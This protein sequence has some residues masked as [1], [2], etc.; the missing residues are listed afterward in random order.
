MMK[1]VNCLRCRFRHED[2][3]NCT[4]VGGFCTAV[5]AAHCPLLREYLDTGLEP[6]EVLPKDK[7]DEIALKL[8]RLSDLE[9]ICSY[10]RLRELAEAD[11]EGRLFLL[12]LEPGRS[13]LC[14][15]YFERP[16]VMKNVAPCVQYHSS[17]GIVFYMGYGVFRGLVEHGKITP[18]SPEGEKALEAMKDD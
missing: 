17:A 1:N 16:W 13:M 12:P 2:N 15:E 7:A 3:G 5:T 4:A 10:T 14:Q 8:M 18:L 6:E 11:K 9:S